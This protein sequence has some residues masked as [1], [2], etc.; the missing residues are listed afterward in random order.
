MKLFYTVPLTSIYIV[1]GII[2][3]SIIFFI[4]NGFLIGK[5]FYRSTGTSFCNANLTNANFVKAD[6]QFTDFIGANC[7]FVNWQEAK[8]YLCKLACFLSKNVEDLCLNPQE[9][10]AKN[11]VNSLFGSLYLQQ[12]DLIDANLN[13]AILV[14]T[15]LRNAKLTNVNLENARLKEVNLSNANLS[16]ANL[17]YVCFDNT[18]LFNANLSNAS[19]KNTDLSF[20]CLQNVNL[21]DAN[22]KNANLNGTD[23]Q[24]VNLSNANLSNTQVLGTNFTG[25][26]FTGAC[27]ENWWINFDTK[28][29][30][31][32]CDYIFLNQKN[33]KDRQ[34]VYAPNSR[35]PSS[36]NFQQGDFAKLIRQYLDSLDL[37]FRNGDDPKVF[38]FALQELL[39]N[40]SEAEIEFKSLDNLGDG[41]I[42]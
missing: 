25:V 27:I 15:D 32:I 12:V 34:V 16:N 19:L 33:D 36:G 39:D 10:R 14:M 24:H 17:N 21:S 2:I 8:F 11:Y 18:S 5:T 13:N 38:A 42:V 26:N 20:I 3:A 6:L 7:D 28:F 4:S 22:L 31:V 40:Y 9:G 29:D 37:M 1:V 35:K 41:D 23:L 30:D